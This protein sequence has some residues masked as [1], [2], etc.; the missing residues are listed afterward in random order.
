VVYFMIESEKMKVNLNFILKLYRR[1]Y[2]R[3]NTKQKR[4][5]KELRSYLNRDFYISYNKVVFLV[6]FLKLHHANFKKTNSIYRFFYG[7]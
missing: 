4:R 2:S 3:K 1:I 5:A 7:L 6:T